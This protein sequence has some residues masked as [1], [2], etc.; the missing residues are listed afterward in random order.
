[1]KGDKKT[2]IKTT[3]QQFILEAPSWLTIL[4]FLSANCD[5]IM[6][7]FYCSIRLNVR[8]AY[9]RCTPPGIQNI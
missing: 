1:M 7:R 3:V 2:N 6:R 9:E 4:C 5:G 8:N